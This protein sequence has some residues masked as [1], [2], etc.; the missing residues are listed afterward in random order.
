[1][2]FFGKRPE[3][4]YDVAEVVAVKPDAIRRGR[5]YMAIQRRRWIRPN[6]EEK[7][8]W[9]YDGPILEVEDGKLQWSTNGSCF[10]ESSLM[11]LHEQTP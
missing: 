1:M 6:G 11:K 7:K 3:P 10:L 5:N 9:V 2:L 8:R 4:R